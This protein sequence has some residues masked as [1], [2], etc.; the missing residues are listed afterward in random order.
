MPEVYKA[1]SSVGG[2]ES[3]GQSQQDSGEKG[4]LFNQFIEIISGIFQPILAVLVASGMIKG[5]LALFVALDVLNAESGTYAIFNAIG[6]GLFYFLPIFLGY[7]SMR[8]FGG[9]PFLG[10]VIA[11][12]LVY[13]TLDPSLGGF[14][15]SEPS[16]M[17]FSGTLFE[18]AVHLEFLGI[19]VILM[20][21]AMSVIPIIIANYFAA[22]LEN[23]LAK[24]IPN[25]IKTFVVPLLTMLIIIPLTFIV[26]GPVATWASQLLGQGTTWLYGLSPIIA[27]AFLGGLWLVFV[28]FGLHWGLVPVALNNF[29][30]QGWDPILALIF[31][32]SFALAGAILAIWIRTRSEKIKSLSFPAFLSAIFGVTEP[33]MYGLALPLKRPFTYTLISSAVGGAI[34]GLFGTVGHEFAGLGVFQWPSF[35]HPEEGLNTAFMGS[36]IAVVVATVLA[37]V[38]T[39]FFGGINK[40]NEESVEQPTQA[41]N[42]EGIQSELI[43]SP[44]KGEVLELSE[45]SDD[46]F[47]S[48]ALGKGVA[49][50]PSEGRLVSPVNGKVSALFGTNHAIGIETEHGAELLI[51]IGIDTVQ[52]NGQHFK[53]HVSQG[54]QVTKGQLLIEFNIDEIKQAGYD[55][56]T[57]VVVTNSNEYQSIVQIKKGL[58]QIGEPILDLES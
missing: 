20:T 43:E 50:I 18:S 46:A 27:G 2:F 25:V 24:V 52:L 1:V 14:A 4:S 48:G 38:L 10:M 58:T 55:I 19:P 16:Y 28:M 21:Y 17:L 9:S 51:H 53:A 15:A 45:T 47:A 56:V 23:G 31:A 29:A 41:T 44:L 37:F 13:P 22:K 42:A 26:I 12:A 30:S 34:I 57:P 5:F 36:V 6:D 33:G 49:I 32:H 39:Y 8:K 7:T 35:V 40:Q 11:S 3:T 54:D